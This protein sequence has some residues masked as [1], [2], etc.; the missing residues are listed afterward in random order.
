MV[1]DIT[2]SDILI[3]SDETEKATIRCDNQPAREIN[4]PKRAIMMLDIS[5]TLEA[6]SY[7]IGKISFRHLREVRNTIDIDIDFNLDDEI[8]LLKTDKKVAIHHLVDKAALDIKDLMRQNEKMK[9]RIG[10][11]ISESN[12]LWENVSAGVY[13]LE[14]LLLW[15]MIALLTLV[16][17]GLTTW[18]ANCL[19]YT[20]PSPRDKRQSRMPSSA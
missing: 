19:L 17:M 12:S 7:E 9:E 3:I 8:R 20:S 16:T 4:I 5:C 6:S 11:Q 14:Q 10:S 13:P 18:V 1:H 2:N 15:G